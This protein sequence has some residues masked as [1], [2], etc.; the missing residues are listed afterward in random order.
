M[1]I[2]GN[3]VL[4]RKGQGREPHPLDYKIALL[5][6]KL[7]NKIGYFEMREEQ[8]WFYGM[9]RAQENHFAF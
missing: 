9:G 6:F 2:S 1:S 5:F 7:Y 4:K 8:S 3:L